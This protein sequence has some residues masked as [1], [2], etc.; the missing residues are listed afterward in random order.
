VSE[1]G[2]AGRA[3]AAGGAGAGGPYRLVVLASGNGGNLQALIDKVHGRP[4]APGGPTVE[5]VL[6][7]SDKPGARALDRAAQAGIPTATCSL[8]S[9]G[10]R[11]AQ[12]AA[13]L[14]VVREATPDL[15]VLAGYMRIVPDDFLR[16]FPWRVI[17]LHPALLPAFP[18]TTSIKDALEHGAK[19]TGVTVHFV[20]GGLDTGPIIAQEAV[21]IEEGETFDSLAERIHAVEHELLPHTVRLLAAGKVRPPLSGTRV[22]QVD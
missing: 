12:E 2:G 16:A 6:V 7:V 20:D 1:A 10:T 22:V 5:I 11:E 15:V 19:V 21:R 17:N 14:Q 3:A 4:A 8:A 18:G 13:L 9:A